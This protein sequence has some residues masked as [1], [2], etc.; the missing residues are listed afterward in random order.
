MAADHGEEAV[1]V[2]LAETWTD[3]P[4]RASLMSRCRDRLERTSHVRRKAAEEAEAKA[5]QAEKARIDEMP[6]E[7]R[8]ANMRRLRDELARSGLIGG[9]ER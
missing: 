6:Q 4:D 2:A 7:Q 1:S 5:R 3:D 9:G 8:E